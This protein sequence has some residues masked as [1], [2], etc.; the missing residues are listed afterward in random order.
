MHCSDY[1]WLAGQGARPQAV[2]LSKERPGRPG[3]A[4]PQGGRRGQ[5]ARPSQPASACRG[6]SISVAGSPAG[7]SF[8][9]G[10]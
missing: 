10:V 1:G 8:S 4:R 5:P 7:S 2:G 3:R 6:S 9:G